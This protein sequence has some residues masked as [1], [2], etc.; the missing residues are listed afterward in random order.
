MSL[1]E[2]FARRFPR[3]RDL[4]MNGLAAAKLMDRLDRDEDS[5]RLLRDL[6]ERFPEH[7]LRPEIEAALNA[8]APNSA[9]G[10]A[11]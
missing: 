2:E 10:I 7:A 1:A 9:G 5:R 11:P 4:V 3:D 8:I 6:L